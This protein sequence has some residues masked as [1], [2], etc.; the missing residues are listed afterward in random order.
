M[1]VL[2]CFVYYVIAQP[3]LI[4][5]AVRRNYI[6]FRLIEL[7]HCTVKVPTA[8]DIVQIQLMLY[9]GQEL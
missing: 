7:F 8:P 3:L 6:V 1:C 9:K 2:T 5:C 4:V